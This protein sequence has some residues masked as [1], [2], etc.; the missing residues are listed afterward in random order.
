MKSRTAV[1]VLA[2]AVCISIAGVLSCSLASSGGTEEEVTPFDPDVGYPEEVSVPL[3]FATV[4]DVPV[5]P[6]MVLEPYA[7]SLCRCSVPPPE[8]PPHSCGWYSGLEAQIDVYAAVERQG[9]PQPGG[10]SAVTMY[11]V[12]E[13]GAEILLQ[14]VSD[15]LEGEEHVFRFNFDAADSSGGAA[16]YPLGELHG[17]K[18]RFKATSATPGEDGD[19]L[20]GVED[21]EL[22]IDLEAP[23][24]TEVIH[25]GGEGNVIPYRSRQVV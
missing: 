21:V 4:E 2:L 1:V 7:P 5:Y 19:A 11:E 22:K 13:M 6:V 9:K 17:V 15:P 20:V 8:N 23:A 14:T 16:A 3:D 10:V 12:D 18:L 25:P 24:I